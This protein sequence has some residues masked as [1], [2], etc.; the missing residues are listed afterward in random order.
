MYFFIKNRTK[1]DEWLSMLLFGLSFS[2][3]PFAIFI[4]IPVVA[5]RHKKIIKCILLY[6]VAAL[7]LLAFKLFNLNNSA[8]TTGMRFL[9]YLFEASYENGLWPIPLFIITYAI[10]CFWAFHKKYDDHE[11]L[12]IW[13]IA[14]LSMLPFYVFIS[15]HPQWI[16][17]YAM[18]FV[19][20]AAAYKNKKQILF[21]DVIFSICFIGYIW[22]GFGTG[23]AAESMAWSPMSTLLPL[24]RYDLPFVGTQILPGGRGVSVYSAIMIAVIIFMVYCMNPWKYKEEYDDL[25][26]EIT[27]KEL[28]YARLRF[29][30]PMIFYLSIMLSW[31]VLSL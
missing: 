21:F 7:P 29:L 10:I 11:P 5:Y 27:K 4:L 25:R 31:Y 15:W 19:I 24:S 20:L 28:I 1:Y 23:F 3:K 12:K 22:S 14:L 17:L 18:L 16:A 30:V 6:V 26:Q 13:Y 9:D 8:G 2:L